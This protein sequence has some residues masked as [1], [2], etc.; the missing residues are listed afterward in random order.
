MEGEIKPKERAEI[1]DGRE[2][3]GGEE[4]A[5]VLRVLITV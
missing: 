5:S 3:D 1:G 2:F 4:D